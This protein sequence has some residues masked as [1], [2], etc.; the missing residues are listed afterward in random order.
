MKTLR[1][2]TI[3]GILILSQYAATRAADV[4]QNVPPDALGFIVIKNLNATDTKVGQLLTIFNGQY[5]SP[6]VFL[7]AVT[8]IHEGLDAQGDFQI[9]MLP[10]GGG[11]DAA[12]RYCVWL[13][14]TDYD[15]LLT[16]LKATLGDPISAVRIADEDLIVAQ[17]GNWA[18]LMDP[19]DR[20]R[21][22]QMLNAD[23]S[24]PRAVVAWKSWIDDNDVAVVL[25]HSGIEQ[26]LAWSAK[27]P[28]SRPDA[29]GQGNIFGQILEPSANDPFVDAADAGSMPNPLYDPLRIAVHKWVLRSPRAKELA[30]QAASIGAGARLDA[31]GNGFASVRLM[32]LNAQPWTAQGNTHV[33]LPV[34][35][36][37]KDDYILRGAGHLPRELMATVASVYVRRMVDDLRTSER[38]ELD[39]KLVA[40]FEQAFDMAAGDVDAWSV[41]HQPG[42]LKTGVYNNSFL[43]LRVPSTKSFLEHAADAMDRWNTM[44][45]ESESETKYVFDIEETKF[46]HR[47]ATQYLLDVGS[48]GGMPALP[49]MRQLMEK[50]FGPGG[51][52][53]MW[54]VPVDE[55]T[56]LLAA[57]TPE[58]VAATLETLER[59]KPIDWNRPEFAA[60]NR[61]L[62]ETVDWRVFF[63]PRGYYDWKRREA[64]AMNNGVPVLG[65]KPATEFPASPSIAFSGKAR[66]NELEV[67]IA[68]TSDTVSSA[69]KYFKK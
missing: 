28:N 32:S 60:A 13:P 39:D 55:Q 22:E 63:S 10:S 58:Q 48:T 43:V 34:A 61:L 59:R 1:R 16:S 66:D 37:E 21:L 3:I 44:H 30:S 31:A 4:V 14:V 19:D 46:S 64:E 12:P 69:G 8:G 24:P 62:P 65:A 56:V 50:F 17:Q 26:M 20:P 57:G 7:E 18:V 33:D 68:I 41:A 27:L 23:R 5:P 6:L 36:F 15:R 67:N 40:E 9:A 35:P 2:I 42:D 45:R 11:R 47:V 49:E 51:K 25:L 38:I 52:M 54:L 53:R 29:E